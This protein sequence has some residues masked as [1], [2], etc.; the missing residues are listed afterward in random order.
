MAEADDS[1][2]TPGPASQRRAC[3]VRET[4]GAATAEL[5]AA[6]AERQHGLRSRRGSERTRRDRRRIAAHLDDLMERRYAVLRSRDD[7]LEP[8]RRPCDPRTPATAHDGRE[9]A[10]HSI[11]LFAIRD[12]ERSRGDRAL[13]LRL[14]EGGRETVA[15]VV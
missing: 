10:V 8:R 14:R 5:A 2:S 12:E 15:V 3:S 1:S 7:G 9:L 6:R 13:G 4:R 11:D